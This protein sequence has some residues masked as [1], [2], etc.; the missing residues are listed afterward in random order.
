MR[1]S[2]LVAL[3]LLTAVLLAV[4]V[5]LRRCYL[6]ATGDDEATA[7]VLAEPSGRAAEDTETLAA[8]DAALLSLDDVGSQGLDGLALET[9]RPLAA[10]S[11]T[12]Y[13]LAASEDRLYM[14]GCDEP[15]QCGNV[16]VVDG[17]S[18]TP[19]GRVQVNMAGYPVPG[20]IQVHGDDLWLWHMTEGGTGETQVVVLD[21]ES[22]QERLRLTLQGAARTLVVMPDGVLR[23]TSGDGAWFYRWA[24]DGSSFSR[25]ANT[26]GALYGDCELLSGS[27]VCAGVREDGTGVI[28]VL[29]AGESSLLARHSA[30]ARTE[31]GGRV[32]GGAWAYAHDSFMFVPESGDLPILWSYILDGV[33]LRQYIPS[34]EP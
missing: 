17:S 30:D 9:L 26:T 33:P 22:L 31:G 10:G 21:R 6:A 25:Q 8:L 18:L 29:D 12:I 1:K 28:D 16:H 20:G 23:G 19:A 24:A 2:C 32:V 34:L 14:A 13:G 3:V 11:A 7:A 4:S 15:G 5:S 27:L